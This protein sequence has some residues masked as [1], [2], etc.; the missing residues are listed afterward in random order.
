MIYYN[1]P[2]N[3]L[4]QYNQVTKVYKIRNEIKHTN[5]ILTLDEFHELNPINIKKDK[6]CELMN[7]YFKEVK[8]E[9]VYEGVKYRKLD[10][11]YTNYNDYQKHPRWSIKNK[12]GVYLL[13]YHWGYVK[14]W[15]Q[16]GYGGKGILYDIKEIKS[17]QWCDLKNCA[18]IFNTQTKEIC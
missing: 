2:C 11:F 15:C 9:W 6:F 14:W 4:I 1:T 7:I 13:V 18:P 10:N 8:H 12:L 16:Y 17:L 3:K 5:K